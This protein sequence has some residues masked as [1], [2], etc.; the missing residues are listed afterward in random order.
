MPDSEPLRDAVVAMKKNGGVA[1]YQPMPGSDKMYWFAGTLY[2]C[3]KVM[4]RLVAGSFAE[5]IS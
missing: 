2:I 5:I 1:S 4:R 3:T